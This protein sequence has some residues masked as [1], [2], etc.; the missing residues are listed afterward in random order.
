[1]TT[2]LAPAPAKPTADSSDLDH[3]YRCDPDLAL[4][5]TDVSDVPEIDADSDITC[6]VC[7]DLDGE[8]CSP[9]CPA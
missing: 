3:L 8:P 4:C 9:G 7:A 5:G 6:V 2:R 1:M